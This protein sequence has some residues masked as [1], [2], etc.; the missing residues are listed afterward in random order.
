M[1]VVEEISLIP[2]SFPAWFLLNLTLC[3]LGEAQYFSYWQVLDIL[4]EDFSA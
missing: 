4:F 1:D 2:I 3:Y